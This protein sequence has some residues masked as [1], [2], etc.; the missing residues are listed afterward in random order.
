MY[1]W[2]IPGHPLP[3]ILNRTMGVHGYYLLMDRDTNA[4]LAD[5]LSFLPIRAMETS[6]SF[7]ARSAPLSYSTIEQFGGVE[8]E[9]IDD[10][11]IY[12][13]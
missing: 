6:A 1:F 4:L 3:E 7:E 5:G 2:K 11:R 9:A 13:L 12:H 8:S 10:K